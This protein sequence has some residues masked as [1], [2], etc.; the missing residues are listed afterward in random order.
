MTPLNQT[1]AAI[2]GLRDPLHEGRDVLQF[3]TP[4]PHDPMAESID[5]IQTAR[6][7]FEFAVI[8]AFNAGDADGLTRLSEQVARCAD[9]LRVV[10]TMARDFQ[11]RM[12]R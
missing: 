6:W 9:G 2:T 3:P 5:A 7:N 12:P 10:E 4:T 8:E 11:G 1:L